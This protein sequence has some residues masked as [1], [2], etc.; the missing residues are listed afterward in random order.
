MVAGKENA[1]ISAGSSRVP[2]RVI[3]GNIS[4]SDIH[5][6][7]QGVKDQD[8]RENKVFLLPKLLVFASWGH[9]A[10]GLCPVHKQRPDGH[11]VQ[12]S[13]IV[14][15]VAKRGPSAHSAIH[16]EAQAAYILA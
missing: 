11:G 13:E 3:L 4:A 7:I 12:R 2:D 16:Y 5:E 15:L 1:C 9:P 10:E 6:A 14:V 8:D